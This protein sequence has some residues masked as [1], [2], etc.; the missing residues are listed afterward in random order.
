MPTPLTVS[1]PLMVRLIIIDI[2]QFECR[3]NKSNTD[4]NV[5]GFFSYNIFQSSYSR[6]SSAQPH[7]QDIQ[8]LV[9]LID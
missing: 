7:L 3:N 6:T 8:G 1:E 2:K 9:L 5:E 4:I